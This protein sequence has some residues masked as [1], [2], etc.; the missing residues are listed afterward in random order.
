MKKFYLFTLML[1][2]IGTVQAKPL[3]KMEIKK[4]CNSYTELA[5][6]YW[7]NY[8]N[9]QSREDQY[10]LVEERIHDEVGV[11]FS[12]KLIDFAYDF[13]PYPVNQR[14]RKAYRED[15]STLFLNECIKDYEASN[16]I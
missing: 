12:K 2:L 6:I 3:E 4:R 13:I 10:N 11:V 9:G 16:Q 7:D 5:L 1:T 15:Y 8:F 14:E